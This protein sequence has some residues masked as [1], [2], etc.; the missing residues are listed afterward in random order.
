MK[1][2]LLKKI[3]KRFEILYYP[4]SDSE[5]KFC[6]IDNNYYSRHTVYIHEAYGI[7]ERYKTKRECLNAILIIVRATYGEYS[8]KGKNSLTKVKVWHNG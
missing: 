1:V 3:R 8:V 6:L 7:K 2:K 4:N 5:R